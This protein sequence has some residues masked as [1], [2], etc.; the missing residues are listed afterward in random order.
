VPQLSDV[1]AGRDQ[2]LTESRWRFLTQYRTAKLSLVVGFLSAIVAVFVAHES[3]PSGYEVSIYQGTPAAFWVFVGFA[4]LIATACAVYQHGTWVGRLSLLLAGTS[5]VTVLALPLIR[6]YYYYGLTDGMNHLGYARKLATGIWSYFGLIYPGGHSTAVFFDAV[7]G[8]GI[9]RALMFSVFVSMLAFVVF[10]PLTVRELMPQS[11][12]VVLA[13]FAGFMIMPI[14]NV[15]TTTQFHPFTMSALLSPLAFYLFFKHLGHGAEDDALPSRLS[16]VSFVLPVAGVALMLY[17]PQAMFDFLVIVVVTA[18]LQLF[19]RFRETDNAITGSRAVAGQA[20]VFPVAFYLWNSKHWQSSAT[21]ERTVAALENYFQGT[22]EAAPNVA[23][24]SESA[25][26]IGASIPELFGKLFLVEAVFSLAALALVVGVMFGWLKLR[27]EADTAVTYLTVGSLVL[28][29]YF[30]TQAIGQVAHNFFRHVGFGM[31]VVTIL[32]PIALVKLWNYLDA[33]EGDFVRPLVVCFLAVC[34]ILSLA[35]VFPSP[36]VYL[37]NHQASEQHMTGWENTLQ[38]QPANT[39]G[40]MFTGTVGLVTPRYERALAGKPGT[41]WYP[42]LVKPFPRG[43][44]TI[45][46]AAVLDLRGFYAAHP[47]K[48]VRR[49]HYLVV[50]AVD[51]KRAVLAYDELRYSEASF[52]SIETQEQVH[53]V[54][55]N[56]EFNAYYVDLPTPPGVAY[57][58]SG[59]ERLN[60]LGGPE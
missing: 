30:F 60:A 14:N 36:F 32:A 28:L 41:P 18:A 42:G 45:S 27:T 49:D 38:Y 48:I 51:R 7:T 23:S 40:P 1:L 53:R 39:E 54:H 56:G 13:A 16:A 47:E 10:V 15:S 6:G 17:H 24:R 31:V 57:N 55:A 59:T 29:P 20:V 21:V 46:E 2:E 8:I 33:R 9:P 50:S 37:Y 58:Q 22:S 26:E 4:L 12:A 43:S 35:A 19:Y 3:P 11:R 34:L 52:E 44:G 25:S 5:T